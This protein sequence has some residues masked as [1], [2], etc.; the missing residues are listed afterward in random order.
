MQSSKLVDRFANNL[1]ASEM[2]VLCVDMINP[3]RESSQIEAW[4][5]RRY[6]RQARTDAIRLSA[7]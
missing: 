7:E 6:R 3:L 5:T 2:A 1:P 4:L